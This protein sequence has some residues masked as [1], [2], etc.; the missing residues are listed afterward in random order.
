MKRRTLSGAL[1][2]LR[3]GVLS[4]FQPQP[5]EARIFGATFRR[6]RKSKIPIGESDTRQDSFIAGGLGQALCD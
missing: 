6:V 1:I 3:V 5:G 2:F 4:F